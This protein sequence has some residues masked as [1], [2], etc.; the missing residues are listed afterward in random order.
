MLAQF[1]TGDMI[2]LAGFIFVVG[3]AMVGM[4]RAFTSKLATE[5]Q[6]NAA[7][8]HANKDALGDM[9]TR[10]VLVEASQDRN[11]EDHRAIFEALGKIQQLLARIAGKLDV[12]E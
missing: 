7:R 10:L 8:A 12:D 9:H 5:R 11:N 3:S 4:W 6:A 1:T 2:A